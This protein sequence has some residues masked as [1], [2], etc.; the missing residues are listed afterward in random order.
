MRPT[1]DRC[2]DLMN[3]YVSD[4]DFVNL[5]RLIQ[6]ALLR[7]GVPI[8]EVTDLRDQLSKEYPS[9]NATMNRELVRLLTYLQDP[10][11]RS[12]FVEQLRADTP[13]VEKMQVAMHAR[14]LHNGW[15]TPLRL[16]MLKFYEDARSLPGGH[17]FAGFLENVSRDFFADFSDADRRPVLA[18]GA[19]WPSSALSVLAKLPERPSPETL[20]QIETL[21]RQVR[22]IQSEPAKKLRIGIIAVLG[23][24]G[25]PEAMAYLREVFEAEPDR[26][27]PIAMGLAQSPD[28]DNWPLLVRS[29]SIVEGTAAQEVLTRLAQVDQ[30][31][32]EPEAYRQVILRG[33]I[34]RENG[35]QHA[36]ALLEKWTGQQL[37]QPNDSWQTALAAWQAWFV[38]KY[39]LLPEP[40]LPVESERNHWTQQ[41]LVSYLTGSQAQSGDA[42]RGAMI[43]EKA[44][45]IR[46]HRFGERGEAIGP[47]LTNVSRRFQKKEILESILYPSQVISD[48]YAG[49]IVV[50]QDGR[51]LTGMVAPSGDGSLTILQANGEKIVV[52]EDDVESNTRSKVSTMPEGLLNQLTLEQ[53]A[54][55]FTYLD[56]LPH[57]EAQVSRRP[58]KPRAK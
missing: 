6:V 27:V 38:E 9:Q 39:P 43:F 20:R 37:S 56:A 3:G 19:K 53:V 13:Q 54:D 55:L 34:L 18:G 4:A 17:S 46:C 42:A 52:A 31:P 24:S 51:T 48:Q 50:T 41:E 47:D 32:D 30:T 16:E 8:E 21:D 14:F 36:V 2:G 49:R 23:A 10:H 5:L 57:G 40:K 58:A 45:C 44:Q 29:L 7:G 22:K 15:N 33:L 35:S 11:A 26:R 1:L 12:A 25:D 28:G